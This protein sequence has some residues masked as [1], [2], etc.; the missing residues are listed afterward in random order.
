MCSVV[1]HL[2]EIFSNMLATSLQAAPLIEA[3]HFTKA[4]RDGFPFSFP[5]P[6]QHFLWTVTA[7]KLVDVGGGRNDVSIIGHLRK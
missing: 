6:G 4:L 1:D 5:S 3:R 7:Q 2:W